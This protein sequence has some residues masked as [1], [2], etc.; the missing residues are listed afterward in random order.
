[1]CTV[2]TDHQRWPT[3]NDERRRACRAVHKDVECLKQVLVQNGTYF[4]DRQVP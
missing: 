4:R 1:M 2:C 3:L